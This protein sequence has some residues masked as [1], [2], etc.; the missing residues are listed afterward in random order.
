VKELAETMK[1]ADRLIAFSMLSLMILEPK[2]NNSAMKNLQN[3]YKNTYSQFIKA[4]YEQNT[5]LLDKLL[6]R[7]SREFFSIPGINIKEK[8][9]TH[10]VPT[11]LDKSCY[12]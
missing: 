4:I 11:N 10:I 7:F 3:K 12:N 6:N 2:I 5:T 9:S 1:T 8:P